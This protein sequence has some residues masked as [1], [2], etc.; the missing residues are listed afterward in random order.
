MAKTRGALPA[1]YPRAC[2][3]GVVGGLSAGN[4]EGETLHNMCNS[5]EIHRTNCLFVVF[6]ADPTKPMRRYGPSRSCF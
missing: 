2:A 3:V 4:V 5:A 1:R 6:R